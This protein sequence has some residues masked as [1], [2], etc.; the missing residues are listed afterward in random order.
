MAHETVDSRDQ[1]VN[2]SAT[3]AGKPL[4]NGTRI[5]ADQILARLADN[6]DVEALLLAYPDLTRG[7]VQAMLADAQTRTPEPLGFVSPQQF[8]R[9]A[10][11][12]EDV[13]RILDA[14]AK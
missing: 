13:R 12:R 11:R 4:A 2:G 7:D 5:A 14:L 1:I 8:Y 3:Q 9:D 6:P 10:I